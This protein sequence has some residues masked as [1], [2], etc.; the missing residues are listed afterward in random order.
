MRLKSYRVLLPVIMICAIVSAGRAQVA[1]T[2]NAPV[3]GQS[4]EGLA[5]VQIF[6][7][8]AEDVKASVIIRVNENTAGNVLV[9]TLSSVP[10]RRG[11]NML[12][13]ATFSRGRF[14]FG[15]SYYGLTLSQTGR[16]PEGEY[17]Y[18]FEIEITDSKSPWVSP[19]FENCFIQQLQP[20]TPLLLINPADG[21]ESCN[22]RPVFLW[23]L[24]SPL[25]AE[26]RC[27][28]VLTELKDKQDIA[29]AVNYNIPVLN[30][31]NIIGNQLMFP[32]S[33]PS[34]KEGKN[35]AWQVI[36][37]TGKAILKRSE[38]WT[39][40]VKCD[41]EIKPFSTDSY[42]ELKEE[43][44]NFYIASKFLRF[45]FHNPY[46]AG[47]L[48]Y[49]IASLAGGGTPIKDL[50]ELKILPGLNKF[51]VDLSEN[52]SFKNGQEYML[53]VRLANNRNLRLRFVYKNE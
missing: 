4:L 19:F 28:L 13:R 18:C 43:D 52:K 12:D 24:P 30:Q 29:E 35:Y 10:L 15:N 23:Q 27:R 8:S 3:Y 14:S 1:I 45:S 9:A 25:P 47:L 38:I 6:N 11:N 21:D 40:S 42:R 37:Y 5:F 31:G 51:D 20:M 22:T 26:A 44:G 2:F 46:N 16:F 32:G 33:A 48:S 49:S 36:V 53:E 41:E 39:Y 7:S 50:P 34:L 17:E